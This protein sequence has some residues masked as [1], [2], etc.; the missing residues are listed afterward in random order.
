MLKTIKEALIEAI[1]QTDIQTDIQDVTLE[2][3]EI[4]DTI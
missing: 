3:K 1:S 2:E 4:I